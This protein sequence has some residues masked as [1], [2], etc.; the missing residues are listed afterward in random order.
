MAALDAL[1]ERL[2]AEHVEQ[3]NKLQKTLSKSNIQSEKIVSSHSQS[4]RPSSPQIVENDSHFAQKFHDDFRSNLEK[5]FSESTA[6][7]QNDK[8]ELENQILNLKN[9]LSGFKFEGIFNPK[10]GNTKNNT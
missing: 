10:V 9:E 3:I 2:I 7:W 4:H 8:Q 6:V 5:Q 1:K